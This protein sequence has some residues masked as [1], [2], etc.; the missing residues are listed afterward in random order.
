MVSFC[1][2]ANCPI[3]DY[4]EVVSFCTE[5]NEYGITFPIKID[6]NYWSYRDFNTGCLG[7]VM[8][9]AWFIMQIDHEG[10][11]MFE[12]THTKGSDL[13][14]ACYGPYEGS[15]KTEVL[16]KICSNAALYLNTDVDFATYRSEFFY[17]LST[18]YYY[19]TECKFA[20]EY[21]YIYDTLSKYSELIDQLMVGEY[22]SIQ[23]V[24]E[25][26]LMGDDD[27]KQYMDSINLLFNEYS[28]IYYKHVAIDPRFYDT[29]SNCYR[30]NVDMFPN[31]KMVDCSFSTNH[32][33]ICRIENAKEGEWYLVLI[34]SYSMEGGDFV[35]EKYAGDAT[36]NCEIVF[37]PSVN[38]DVCEGEDILF[39]V[40]NVPE[41][42]TFAWTGPNGFSSTLRS[43]VISNASKENE[44]TYS[45]QMTVGDKVTP[46]VD[47][48][49][50]VHEQ[51]RTD[52][53]IYI[54]RGESLE[55]A[56]KNFYVSGDYDIPFTSVYGCDSIVHLSVRMKS[57]KDYD[58]TIENNGPLCEGDV[59]VLSA[60]NVPSGISSQ[61]TGPNG[62]IS[63][64]FTVVL[65]DVSVRDSGSYK[66]KF[67]TEKQSLDIMSTRV[68][69]Y[70]SKSVDMFDLK[71]DSA[72]MFNGVSI[73]HAGDYVD[74]FEG[75][76][77][78]DSTVKLHVVE[79][80][81]NGPLCEG[82][83]LV[84]SARS[85]PKGTKFQWTAPD[86]E[87]FEDSLIVIPDVTPD[88]GGDYHLE[89][90]YSGV[91]FN[92]PPIQVKINT[93]N[94]IELFDDWKDSVFLF[95][96]QVVDRVGD[97]SV[98]M[99]N[100]N[101]CDSVIT[102]HVQWITDTMPVVPDPYF[103]PN[104]DGIKDRWFINGVDKV[105]TAVRI[106]D[107]FG[108]AIRA[109]DAYS[110]EDGWDGKDTNGHDMPSADYWFV[111]NVA[112]FDR[113]FVGHVALVR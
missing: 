50:F 82:E 97:Y 25:S 14:F 109:Y 61:W 37:D 3:S 7:E 1:A 46:V 48:E 33:E 16:K 2:L 11:L 96:D 99:K 15:S 6:N 86:G 76:N 17:Y 30:A 32:K 106:Y 51:S 110:N 94:N 113:L 47:L 62:F 36:T 31:G 22:D 45:V 104:G 91:V 102:L 111:V 10:S 93:T 53:T 107:R 89:T 103:S 42:A 79:I 108:K 60:Q 41:N 98:R 65:P 35:F 80:E 63:E 67:F 92:L 100:E 54:L 20:D 52:T 84:L 59:L 74:K 70:P 57:L 12:I 8:Y 66:A 21:Q 9:P 19:N 105:P 34:S 18:K 39:T 112:K 29:T 5:E 49:V 40:N 78:C 27:Y 55:F 75:A 95:Y 83:T 90:S 71:S 43:P 23:N 81:N 64:G 4:N 87:R 88:D 24:H 38:N 77:G 13:D 72:S 73:D 56:G 44:G 68:D 101:G 28:D 58:I 26:G 69:V 85:F